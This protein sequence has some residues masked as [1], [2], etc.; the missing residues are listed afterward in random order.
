MAVNIFTG[1]KIHQNFTKLSTFNALVL[2]PVFRQC[3]V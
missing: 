3:F 2:N 1:I